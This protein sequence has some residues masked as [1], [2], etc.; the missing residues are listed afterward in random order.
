MIFGKIIEVAIIDVTKP[1]VAPI[2]YSR[3]LK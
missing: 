2:I 3:E 1:N